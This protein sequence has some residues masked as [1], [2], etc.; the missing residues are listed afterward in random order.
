MISGA[1]KDPAKKDLYPMDPPRVPLHAVSRA[2]ATVNQLTLVDST[3]KVVNGAPKS[4]NQGKRIISSE[5]LDEFKSAVQGSDLTKTGLIEVLK[6]RCA[7]N[8]VSKSKI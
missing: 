8:R 3:G 1:S 7:L 2:N 6:K 4:S 5:Y